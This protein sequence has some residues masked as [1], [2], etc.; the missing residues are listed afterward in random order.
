VIFQKV[1]S[2]LKRKLSWCLLEV[3]LEKPKAVAGGAALNTG[4]G[5]VATALNLRTNKKQ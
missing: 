5:A 4:P 1:D 3:F 2:S